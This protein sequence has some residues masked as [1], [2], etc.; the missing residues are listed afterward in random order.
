MSKW[1]L[2][3]LLRGVDWERQRWYDYYYFCFFFLC[4]TAQLSHYQCP[5]LPPP[6]FI[7]INT[8]IITFTHTDTNKHTSVISFYIQ[9]KTYFGILPNLKLILPLQ[10]MWNTH[11]H[12]QILL[13]ELSVNI[14]VQQRRMK[15]ALLLVLGP[16]DDQSVEI[17][18]NVSI[19]IAHRDMDVGG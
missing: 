16:W 4:H 19:T 15:H 9:S 13:H 7:H 1:A 5:T 14:D 3:L 10:L 6:N 11:T 17:C 8:L 12:T 18:G 2:L